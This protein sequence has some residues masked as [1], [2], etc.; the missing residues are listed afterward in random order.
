VALQLAEQGFNVKEL[1][2]GWQEWTA[3]SLPTEP[4][5]QVV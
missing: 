3:D 5:A 2:V 4:G 1:N